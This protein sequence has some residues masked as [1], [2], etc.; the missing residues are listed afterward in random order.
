MKIWKHFTISQYNKKG[1]SLLSLSQTKQQETQDILNKDL[2][3]SSNDCREHCVEAFNPL[4][5]H[6]DFNLCEWLF[7][8]ST[9]AC[10]PTKKK[11]LPKQEVVKKLKTLVKSTASDIDW[12][13]IACDIAFG[14]VGCAKL[15]K[16]RKMKALPKA[17]FLKK[18][19]SF[20]KSQASS[21]D[22]D[23]CAEVLGADLCGETM[24]LLPTLTEDSEKKALAKAQL[25]KKI[26]SLAKSHASD[27]FMD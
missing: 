16:Q 11:A 6:V 3:L 2:Y 25:A 26:K 20:A 10:E 8:D 13:D 12:E 14:G 19:K 4:A 7:P 23:L 24:N 15:K 21:K 9:D 27:A 22:F 1:Q 5:K 18:I 17:E